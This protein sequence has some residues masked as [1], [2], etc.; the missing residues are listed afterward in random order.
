M[1]TNRKNSGLNTTI[2]I[3]KTNAELLMEDAVRGETCN[4]RVEELLEDRKKYYILLDSLKPD[5]AMV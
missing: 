2:Q 3:T 4:S 5:G 1:T